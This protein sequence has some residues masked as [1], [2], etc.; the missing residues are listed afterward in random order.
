MTAHHA[1]AL[2]LVQ[3]TST[4]ANNTTLVLHSVQKTL[5]IWVNLTK[6]YKG[7]KCA[8]LIDHR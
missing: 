5:L 8:L 2:M 7:R 6:C 4:A 1:Y 3:L